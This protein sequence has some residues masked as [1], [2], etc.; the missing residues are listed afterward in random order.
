MRAPE[1]WRRDGALAHALAPLSWAWAAGARARGFR[2]KPAR[3][4]APV[5]CVGNLTVGGTGKT[6]TALALLH[7]LRGRGRSPHALTRGYGGGLA[8][9]LRVE[10]EHSAAQVGDEALLLAQAAPTWVARDRAAGAR[11]AVAAGADVVVMDDGHQ[12]PTLAK[13]LSLIVVDGAYGFGNGRLLPAGPLREPI[14]AGLARADAIVLVL[15]TLGE[16]P[17]PFATGGLPVLR[18]R[19]I[20]ELQAEGFSGVRVLAF[21]GIG[22]PEKFFATLAGLRAQVVEA[23]AFA[24]HHAYAPHE[25]MALVEKAQRLDAVPI[26]TTKDAMRLPPD[27]RAMV[28]VLRVALE[29]EEPA[30]LEALL[31]RV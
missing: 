6:P 16:A 10:L 17:A 5:I 2:A 26:T 9:P 21:A 15:P 22:R 8:G 25:V 19:L 14:G 24:D 3:V 18:A 27:A 20:P 13:D 4:G 12:N 1:F 7:H 29:F 28:Q 23:H 11:A 30:A 31:D